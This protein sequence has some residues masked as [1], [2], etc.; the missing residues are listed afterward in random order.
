MEQ[1]QEISQKSL[2][3]K[4]QNYTFVKN[5]TAESNSSDTTINE[6]CTQKLTTCSFPVVLP[7]QPSLQQQSLWHLQSVLPINLPSASC[8][9]TAFPLSAD[10]IAA[11]TEDN[12]MHSLDWVNTSKLCADVAFPTS[13]T[14]LLQQYI[15][16]S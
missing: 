5:L 2:N 4:V 9:L 12:K 10:D 3:S 6:L 14:F 13:I 11:K 7:E 8:E 16:V 1:N 15:T